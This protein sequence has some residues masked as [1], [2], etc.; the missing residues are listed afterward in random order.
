MLARPVLIATFLVSAVNA[1]GTD[2]H[3]QIGLA[4]E[5]FLTPETTAIIQRILEP[6]YEGSIGR[7]AAW[8]DG[9]AHTA[10]GSFSYP[11]HWIDS[12][13]NPPSLCS[14]D[15]ARD[16][17]PKGCVV[18]A[19][20]NQTAILRGCVSRAI[21]GDL[22]DGSDIQCSQALKWV[23]HFIGDVAQPLH[24]S[25]RA[26]G[27]N[28]VRVVYG[29]QNTELH[30]VWD[31]YI[32]HS[33]A[34]LAPHTTFP[35]DSLSPFFAHLISRIRS[36]DFNPPPSQT[37]L[38]C[39]DP[40]TPVECA[41]EWASESN[42]WTCEYVY[43]MLRGPG[44]DGDDSKGADAVDLLTNGYAQGAFGIVETQ[45][46]KAAL[47]LATWLNMIVAYELGQQQEQ[48]STERVDLRMIVQD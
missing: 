28:F 41:L 4:A 38:S 10:N 22:V 30:A 13:D 20:A 37:W 40:A 17:P 29:G 42:R 7:A 1:W 32:L 46:G 5:A 6:Y 35:H 36:D 23:T 19:I 8:A 48:H 39:A 16:C 9:Y 25:G 11:W 14:L 21:S 33:D 34:N 47:R 18:A 44:D 43:L 24:A 2:V 26:A 15:F 45:V 27:G 3:N 12:E 31:S